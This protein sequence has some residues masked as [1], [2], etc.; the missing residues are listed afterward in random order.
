MYHLYR[1]DIWIGY[2]IS[3]G[4]KWKMHGGYIPSFDYRYDPIDYSIMADE[5]MVYLTKQESTKNP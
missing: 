1:D 3:K 5:I 4:V 2:P